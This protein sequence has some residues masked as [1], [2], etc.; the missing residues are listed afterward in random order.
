MLCPFVPTGRP[1]MALCG[2]H[3]QKKSNFTGSFHLLLQA[4]TEQVAMM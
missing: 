3:T 1:D 2:A 4:V